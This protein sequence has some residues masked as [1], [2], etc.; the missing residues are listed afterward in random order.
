MTTSLPNTQ[1]QQRPTTNGRPTGKK[2]CLSVVQV[3]RKEKPAVRLKYEFEQFSGDE[4]CNPTV[5][6]MMQTLLPKHL[7]MSMEQLTEKFDLQLQLL[8]I[9]FEPAEFIDIDPREWCAERVKDRGKYKVLLHLKLGNNSASRIVGA[10]KNVLGNVGDERRCDD[11]N[12]LMS[13]QQNANKDWEPIYRFHVSGK[14]HLGNLYN[15]LSDN[16]VTSNDL[17][18]M[19]K[20]FNMRSYTEQSLPTQG[21]E[22]IEI[23]HLDRLEERTKMFGTEQKLSVISRLALLDDGCPLGQFLLAASQ[24]KGQRNSFGVIQISPKKTISLKL[25][26]PMVRN[27][28]LQKNPQKDATHFVG[29]TC[30]GSLVAAI[31]TF[32]QQTFSMEMNVPMA[33]KLAMKHIRGYP[34]TFSD[35]G[36]LNSLNNSI[37]MSVFVDPSIGSGGTDLQFLHGLDMF[38]ESTK[39]TAAGF[40]KGFGHPISFSLIP[41]SAIVDDKSLHTFLPTSMIEDYGLGERIQSCAQSLEYFE[42]EFRKV[43]QSL[44]EHAFSLS[45]HHG[46]LRQM[47]QNCEEQK[48]AIN[49]L[50]KNFVIDL[51]MGQGAEEAERLTEMLELAV[52]QFVEEGRDLLEHCDRILRPRMELIRQLDSKGVQYIG[53]GKQRLAD[54]LLGNDGLGT[55]AS[56]TL[57]FVLLYR[58]SRTTPPVD[59]G[60]SFSQHDG[61]RHFR[62]CLGQLYQLAGRGKSCIFVDLDVL[63]RGD[64][65]ATTAYEG[66][67]QGIFE[68]D[69]FS[70]IA[71]RLVKM[72]GH[73]LLTADC[74]MEEAQKL[75]ICIAQIENSQLTEVEAV[76]QKKTKPCNLRCPLSESY[77]GKCQND[78]FLWG[79]DDCG[80]T[81]AFVQEENAPMTHFY[82]A[83]GATPVEEFSFRCCDVDTH[84]R[85]FKQFAT[86]TQLSKELERLK[87]T[88]ILTILL[89]GE[90][91]VGKSTLINAIVNYLK[92]PTFEEAI[93][94]DEIESVIPARFCTEEYDEDGNL[95]QT[96]VFVGKLSKDECLEPG[97]SHTIRPN[98]YIIPSKVGHKIRLIDTP[99][100]LNTGGIQVDN[101]NLHKTLSFISTLPELHAICILLKS[102]NTRSGPAFKYCINGLLTYLHKNAAK[103]IFFMFTNARESNYKMEKTEE[104]L[105]A[106]LTP[107]E[108]AHNAGVSIPLH[109]DKIYCLDNEAFEHLC[110]IKKANVQYSD[111]SMANFSKSWTQAKHEL[112]RMLQN[113]SK[114]K[115]HRIS[116]TVSLNKAHRA[117]IDLAL[118]LVTINQT[119]QDNLVRIK[120]HEEAISRG[121]QELTIG[122]QHLD[123]AKRKLFEDK[124]RTV[125]TLE[126][127]RLQML[128]EREKI[129][130]KAALFC[131][132]LKTWALKPYNDSME[133]YILFSIENGGR[134]V[135]ESNGE[136][137]RK[138]QVKKLNGLQELLRLYKEQTA[139]IDAANA[140]NTDGPKVITAEDVAKCFEEL[141]KLPIFGP[142]IKQTYE[143]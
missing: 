51:R 68:L 13:G 44:N 107:I 86:K 15:V 104:F 87:C 50:L 76:P 9:D 20:V 28:V 35:T 109:Q 53:R 75:Q 110:L 19:R 111:E 52:E 135:V 22:I 137:D 64:N 69:G 122:T 98:A 46:E 125:S 23:D 132:F 49:D 8:D 25:D 129:Y 101:L 140:N 141:R 139:L 60:D 43:G 142:N 40:N 32:D 85:E 80:Q 138:L 97:K 38:V 130:S 48:A 100:I 18:F 12:V 41:L 113:V 72:R 45:F 94:A 3:E 93:Q 14:Y 21:K 57:H 84:G 42:L 124:R 114:L 112:Q 108:A 143:A 99:S 88:G 54:V 73:K 55:N 102:N 74:V 70:N 16:F 133:A 4:H 128:H 26:V 47:F 96:E 106:I 95:V 66:L 67:P 11:G 62:Q 6:H 34:V 71:S 58:E 121:E 123:E 37:R 56:S 127:Y 136:A 118:P 115:P 27:T 10:R 131:S 17:G 7:A 92:H 126:S 29:S 77:G 5:G 36:T 1:H 120:E 83:C 103:N 24:T 39:K 91:G 89:L 2:K 61:E 30:F 105:Q 81:L 31:V 82:C 119:I 117:I 33:K 78:N 63:L 134:L 65:E 79:C 116:E 90:T 59:D